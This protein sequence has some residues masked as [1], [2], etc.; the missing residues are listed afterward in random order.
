V[1]ESVESPTLVATDVRVSRGRTVVLRDVSLRCHA[2]ELLA[3]LGPNGAGKSTLVR[4]L[5]GLLPY[6]GSVE[7]DGTE[8][9]TLSPR[10]R[11]R[12][13]AFVPQRS[14]LRSALRV[15]EVVAQGRYAH[16]P[17]VDRPGDRH[18]PIV[19]ALHTVGLQSFARRSFT[20]LSVGEQQRVLLA[21]ALAGESELL[22]LDEPT[23]PLDV[24]H[25]LE[26]FALLRGLAERGRAVLVVMH[27]LDDARRFADRAVL[28]RDGALETSGPS[29]EV[30]EPGAVRAVYGVDL[31]ENAGLSFSLP[32]SGGEEE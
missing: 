3:V 16:G 6:G 2:G 24:R 30:I 27:E 5:A 12:R 13:I 18:D 11:A 8:V 7:V 22:I 1:A 20:T 4:A 26:T 31:H 29:S 28:L 9:S 19:A 17:G 14:G 21:R 10:A 32:D 15:E 23:A 25:S